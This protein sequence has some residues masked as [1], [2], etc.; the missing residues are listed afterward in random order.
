MPRFRARRKM[1]FDAACRM[2]YMLAGVLIRF[3]GMARFNKPIVSP[4]GWLWAAF[5]VFVVPG[6]LAFAAWLTHVIIC[7]QSGQWGFLIAGALCF[8]IGVVHGAGHWFGAW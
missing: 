8:P 6:V 5:W 2:E 1:G 4:F 7:I 3:F